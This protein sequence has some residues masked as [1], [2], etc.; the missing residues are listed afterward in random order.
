MLIYVDSQNLAFQ[1]TKAYPIYEMIQ[2]NNETM[3]YSK[4]ALYLTMMHFFKIILLLNSC[5]IYVAK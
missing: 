3:V 1:Q 2:R 4:R 5:H